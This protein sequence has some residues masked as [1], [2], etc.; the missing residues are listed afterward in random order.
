MVMDG[1]VAILDVDWLD[2]RRHAVYCEVVGGWWSKYGRGE[3][4]ISKVINLLFIFQ[5]IGI[6][7]NFHNN[8]DTNIF[9]YFLS[10][11]F[12]SRGVPFF[13]SSPCQALL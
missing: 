7:C 2:G 13:K 3:S 11:R 4:I 8:I 1:G 9:Q 10:Q 12:P 6:I 5:R